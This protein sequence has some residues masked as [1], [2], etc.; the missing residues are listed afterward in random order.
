MFGIS[1]FHLQQLYTDSINKE[2][3]MLERLADKNNDGNVSYTEFKDFMNCYPYAQKKAKNYI[4]DYNNI[5]TSPIALTKEKLRLCVIDEKGINKFTEQ[6]Q[7]FNDAFE[8]A[9]HYK[10]A[11][12]GSRIEGIDDNLN[13]GELV[14]FFALFRFCKDH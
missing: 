7:A 8:V 4:N 10:T 13:Y 11:E 9:N 3:S 1:N 5:I 6:E 12:D 2:R 14:D